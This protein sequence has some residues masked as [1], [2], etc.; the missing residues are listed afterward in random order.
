MASKGSPILLGTL[1]IS[2]APNL[3]LSA[4]S[5]LAS[6]HFVCVSLDELIPLPYLNESRTASCSFRVA[7]LLS[8][9]CLWDFPP[10]SLLPPPLTGNHSHCEFVCSAFGPLLA[11]VCGSYSLARD[12]RLELLEEGPTS[13]PPLTLILCPISLACV[14][15][16]SQ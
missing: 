16:K 6:T 1:F 11:C 2:H 12:R 7:S 8:R 9:D 4:A 15:V 10:S 14:G 3:G 5:T 13:E